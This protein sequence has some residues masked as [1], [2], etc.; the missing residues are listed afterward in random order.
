MKS[1]FKCACGTTTRY[2]DKDAQKLVTQNIP[3][4]KRGSRTN[5]KR[6]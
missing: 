6:N 5:Q 4:G 2:T 3:K 1:K